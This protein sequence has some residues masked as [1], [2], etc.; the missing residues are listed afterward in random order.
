MT[1]I[2]ARTVK[3]AGFVG[4]TRGIIS[5]E[6][7]GA[8]STAPVM[9]NTWIGGVDVAK[10]ICAV[11]VCG[12]PVLARGWCSPHW[13]RWSRTGD[14][15]ADLPVRVMGRTPYERVMATVWYIDGHW[16]T[17]AVDTIHGYGQVSAGRNGA[18]PLKSHRVT[19]EHH[20]GSIPE[21]MVIDHLC[22]VK[23]CVNPDHLEVVT[24]SE[25]CRRI[26]RVG[27]RWV[28]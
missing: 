12:R 16:I 5:T 19:Y 4:S 13:A 17:T 21:G 27:R 25:N 9:A 22:R 11:P 8:A 6:G 26:D 10:S 24:Q 28:A 18:S 20:R 1:S 7:P 23:S 15:Q 14:V 2:A 3:P